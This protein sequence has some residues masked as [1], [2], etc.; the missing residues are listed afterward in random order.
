MLRTARSNPSFILQTLRGATVEQKDLLFRLQEI[1]ITW[2]KIRQR[3]V[4]L[5]SLSNGSPTLQRAREQVADLEKELHHWRGEQND[6]ELEARALSERINESE[7]RLLSG[8]IH[9][10]K[11]LQALQASVDALRRQR[12]AVEDRSVDALMK[13]EELANRLE[14]QKVELAAL[15]ESWQ[16]K[17]ASLEEEL[18]KR[19]QEYVY[20]KR[21]RE[22]IVAAIDTDLIEQYNYLRKRKNG[23]AVARLQEDACSACFMQV[24]TG[25]VSAVRRGDTLTYCPSC[26]RI[27]FAD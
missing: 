5:Q 10:P 20:L 27:L 3:L 13:A 18:Q 7:Q 19:K 24:P 4:K 17:Q 14:A 8:E 2:E 11:E 21:L 23:I 22:Q 25:V 9:N 1:D 16:S 15:E 26:G 12:D 6:A